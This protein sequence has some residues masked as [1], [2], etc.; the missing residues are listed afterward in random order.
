MSRQRHSLQLATAFAAILIPAFAQAA[1]APLYATNQTPGFVVSGAPATARTQFENL[2]VSNSIVRDGLSDYAA[3]SNVTSLA[4]TTLGATLTNDYTYPVPGDR[5]PG[6]VS[7]GDP[8]E[9][10]FDTTADTKKQ[11]WETK[12]SFSLQFAAGDYISALGFYGTDFGDFDG[13]FT[14]ELIRASDDKSVFVPFAKPAID[15]G[16]TGNGWL[17]FFAFYDPV[18]TYKEVRF[19]ITQVG[20]DINKWDV[21]GF[22]DFV[23]GDLK[24]ASDVPEPGSIALVGASLL[25][26]G[27]T[28]RRRKA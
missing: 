25:A 26:L 4:M 18:D 17:Q 12:Y 2:L 11:W 21:L 3:A 14:L 6:K 27:L 8:V 28:R 20:T 15:A 1:P 19:N 13:S 10:R 22:D 7:A 5:L 9:G 24:P 23:Y 16:T